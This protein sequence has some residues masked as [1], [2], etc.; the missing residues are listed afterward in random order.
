MTFQDA[1]A[2][3]FVIVSVPILEPSPTGA[4]TVDINGADLSAS[5]QPDLA[6]LFANSGNAWWYDAPGTRVWLRLVLD[7]LAGG[8]TIYESA[9]T[10]ATV[11]SY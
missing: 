11:L 1:R 7:T 5:P 9:S 2:D 8:P 6:N 10:T 4:F 3:D